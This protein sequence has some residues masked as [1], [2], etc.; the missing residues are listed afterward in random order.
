MIKHDFSSKFADLTLRHIA[1]QVAAVKYLPTVEEDK[2]KKISYKPITTLTSYLI[3]A[4]DY[5]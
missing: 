2:I 4:C 1:C 3:S 5:E